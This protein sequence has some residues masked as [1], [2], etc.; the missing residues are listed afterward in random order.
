MEDD[1]E[2]SPPEPPERPRRDP[3]RLAESNAATVVALFGLLVIGGGLMGLIAL[4][5]PQ[6]MAVLLVVGGLF[7]LPVA[8]HYLVWGWWLSQMRERE[9]KEEG[10]SG[11][12]D[13]R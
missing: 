7:V 11:I 12:E 4:V 10:G 2:Q 8:F 5:L 13:R 3:Q 6:F 1:P 9:G